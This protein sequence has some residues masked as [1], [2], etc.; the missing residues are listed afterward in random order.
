MLVALPTISAVMAFGEREE[1]AVPAL[2]RTLGAP[3]VASLF[4]APLMCFVARRSSS[5]HE[6]TLIA[7]WPW[8]AWG[9]WRGEP[10]TK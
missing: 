2:A 9:Y 5:R 4:R 10:T 6:N 7:L 3:R 1:L 8:V